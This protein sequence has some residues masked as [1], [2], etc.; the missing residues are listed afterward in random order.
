M[1]SFSPAAEVRL[2]VA[3]CL[4]TLT[5]STDDND[6]ITALQTLHSYLDEGAESKT[7]SVQRAEFRRAHF[8]RTLQFLVS[9]IQADWLHSLTAAHRTELWDGLFL[10]GPPEQALLVLMEAIGDLRWVMSDRGRKACSSFFL[11]TNSLSPPQSRHRSEPLGQHNWKV[12]SE[13]STRWPAVVPLCGGRSLWL[14]P[15]PRDSAGTCRGPA[16]PHR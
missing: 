4:R 6:I 14:P 2:A 15:A 16:R 10:R 1:E 3:Q 7:T 9:N 11:F 12:P 8:T 5:T 13:W